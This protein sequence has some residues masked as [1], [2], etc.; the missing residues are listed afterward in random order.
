MIEP[1]PEKIEVAASAVMDAAFRVHRALG[2]GLLETVYEVCLAHEMRKAGVSF[3]QQLHVP[4]NY[5]GL[6][7]D[8]GLRL[9]LLV[10]DSVIVELKAIEKLLPVHEAQVLTYLKLSNKRLRLLF[11]FNTPL[12][13]DGFKRIIL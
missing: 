11:N 12:L 1:L 2:P 5:D 13:K 6:R 8:T 9:D 10:D 7:F 3:Q 4:I